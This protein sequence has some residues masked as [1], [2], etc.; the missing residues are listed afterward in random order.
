MSLIQDL[1]EEA[2][3]RA[4]KLPDKE[5]LKK[6]I[7]PNF[8]D[9]LRDKNQLAVIAEFK[10]ASPSLGEIAK[11]DLVEQITSYIQGGASALS[12]L[13]EPLRFHGSL[14]DLELAAE[15]VDIPILMKDFIIHPAQIQAAARLSASAVLL[16]VSCLSRSE[17]QELADACLH[18][19]LV[20]LIECRD[21][22][23]LELGMDIE[24][25]VLGVNNRNLDTLEIDRS[26]APRLLRTIPKDRITVAESGYTTPQH[27]NEIRG[28]ADA[29]LIG[30][31]LMRSKDPRLFLREITQ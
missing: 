16:I 27:A 12:I 8:G 7:R 22:K 6:S 21:E 20:P 1:I 14:E 30:S 23:E 25:A 10:Q 29:V 19:G 13:T 2:R 3:E 9:A 5:P 24:G 28:I 15:S 17:L 26:L 31:A 11:P 4:L 18:Y